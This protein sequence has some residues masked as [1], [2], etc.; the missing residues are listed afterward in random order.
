MQVNVSTVNSPDRY[1]TLR[2]NDEIY[3]AVS[4]VVT[5][6]RIVIDVKI[7]TIHILGGTYL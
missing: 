7:V 6:S 2:L 1:R 4:V 3:F 5:Y